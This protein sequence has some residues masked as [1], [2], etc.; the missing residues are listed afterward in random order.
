VAQQ[1]FAVQAQQQSAQQHQQMFLSPKMQK[2]M[3]Q[4][5]TQMQQ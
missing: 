1:Q 5:Q 2:Q 3:H 4:M